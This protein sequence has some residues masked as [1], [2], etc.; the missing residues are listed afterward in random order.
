MDICVVGTGYVGLVTGTCFAELGV[1]VKCVDND[2]AKIELLNSGG[3]PI[4]EPGLQELIKKNT[5]EGRL[6]FTTD[7]AEAIGESLVVFIAVGTPQGDD[8][9][10]DLQYVYQVAETIG[11]DMTAYKV[12]VTK[13]TVPVGTGERIRKIVE[14]TQKER[15]EFDVVSNPEFLRKARLWRISCGRTGS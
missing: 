7:I 10:A 12:I 5:A 14:R 8:G 9:S 6:S 1:T 11:R 13:S 4:Y 2:E 15:I 3:V